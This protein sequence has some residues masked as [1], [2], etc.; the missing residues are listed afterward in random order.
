MASVQA[1][2]LSGRLRTITATWPARSTIKSST[3]SSVPSRLSAC[4]IRPPSC[5]GARPLNESTADGARSKTNHRTL[6]TESGMV[7]SVTPR[8]LRYFVA[9][10]DELHFGRAAQRLHISQPP[11]SARISELEDEVGFRLFDRS[12]QMV[13]LTEEGARFLRQAR[14]VL[15]AMEDLE[16]LVS[17]QAPGHGR[18]VRVAVPP[19]TSANVFQD[20]TARLHDEYPA[21]AIEFEEATTADQH[22]QLH[23]GRLDVVVLRHPFPE[24]GLVVGPKLIKTLGVLMAA[25][26]PLAELPLIRLNDLNGQV[27]VMFRREVSPWLYDQTLSI[28]N[29]AGYRPARIEYATRIVQR[30]TTRGPSNR[31]QR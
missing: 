22:A 12:S 2:N 17:R 15:G 27:L 5:A 4:R 16:R 7:R 20:V 24:K 29:D 23:Q 18:P 28:C 10:A 30:P 8:Q 9:V 19:D 25:D 1:F 11:L 13:K 6:H 3:R 14:R 21:A 31:I 26:H